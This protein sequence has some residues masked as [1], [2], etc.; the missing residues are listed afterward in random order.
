M[1]S[2]W[3]L[4]AIGVAVIWG[5]GEI[6]LKKSIS[7]LGV[8]LIVLLNAWVGMVIWGS[9]WFFH[10]YPSFIF[11]SP[12]TLS[13]FISTILV[14]SGIIFYFR[15]LDIKLSKVSLISPISGATPLVTIILAVLFLHENIEFLA[16]MGIT[17]VLS[18][19]YVLGSKELDRKHKSRT[20]TFSLV[21]MLLWGLGDVLAKYSIDH[22]GHVI[23]LGITFTTTFIL[24]NI[25]GIIYYRKNG[26]PAEKG[27]LLLGTA[28]I[29]A[30]II[31]GLML[32]LA[33]EKGPIS[34]ISPVVATYSIF[35]IT[36]AR[37]F[38]KEKLD[39]YQKF[40]VSLLILGAILIGA[41]PG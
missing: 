14:V 32:F 23:F 6:L 36:F 5:I 12:A 8:P 7:K 39:N 19:I 26:I 1:V 2:I 37:I 4:L 9:Y 27:Q 41:S 29:A 40:A 31:G 34:L 20:Y 38:L 15:A 13:A 22:I 24:C 25:F 30:Y 33:L 3:F 11:L 21:A 28:G 17:L 18:G 10:G 35:T 16:I